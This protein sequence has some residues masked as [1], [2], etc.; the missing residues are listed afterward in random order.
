MKVKATKKGFY[1]KLRRVDDEFILTSRLVGASKS[2]HEQDVKAQ[3]SDNWMVEVSLPKSK[4]RSVKV[5]D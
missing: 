2:Q 5:K 1:K 3:F 4:S